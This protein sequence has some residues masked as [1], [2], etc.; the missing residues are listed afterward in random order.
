M[1]RKVQFVV[2]LMILT[3]CFSSRT[4]ADTAKSASEVDKGEV[5]RKGTEARRSGG[6]GTGTRNR[7]SASS[8]TEQRKS[9]TSETA[10]R[11]GGGGGGGAATEARGA[12]AADEP[13][14]IEPWR[15]S[16]QMQQIDSPNSLRIAILDSEDGNRPIAEVLSDLVE[17]N[18]PFRARELILTILLRKQEALPVLGEAL[19]SG[20]PATKWTVLS[21]L[22]KNLGWREMSDQVLNILTDPNTPDKVLIR[23]VAAAA[24]LDIKGGAQ[25]IRAVFA[26]SKN[27]NV[28]EVA[29]RALGELKHSDAKNDLRNALKDP[30]TRIALAAAESLGKMDDPNGYSI[31]AKHLSHS[32]WFIR[33]LAAQAL[34]QI[35]TD[36]AL[37]TLELHLASEKSPT[38]KAETEI[39]INRISMKRKSKAERLANLSQLL[40][41]KNRFVSRW[42]HEHILKESP[43]ASIPIFSQRTIT[44]QGK[45]RKAA[46]IYLLLAEERTQERGVRQ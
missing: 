20:S 30:T 24:V 42:A 32:N 5:A 35:G 16:S 9:T 27:D 2:I 44:A 18:N 12:I 19:Q 40:D 26:E 3:L 39:S 7:S 15:E 41:S 11:R 17:E 25:T 6:G 33:K 1:A 34:G 21:L 45:L 23:A 28:R 43:Q 31:A 22:C 38:A 10:G 29:I 46:Q 4:L 37:N 13:N 14:L 36:A 8:R